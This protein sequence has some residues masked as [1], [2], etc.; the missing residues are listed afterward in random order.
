LQKDRGTATSLRRSEPYAGVVEQRGG[1]K[2]GS[3]FCNR[4]SRNLLK[5]NIHFAGKHSG[6]TT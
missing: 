1:R 6:R 3:R 2:N 5:K 4:N